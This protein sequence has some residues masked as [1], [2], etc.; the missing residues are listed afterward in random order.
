MILIC[1]LLC[2]PKLPVI[3]LELGAYSASFRTSSTL[4]RMATDVAYQASAVAAVGSEQSWPKTVVWS[5]TPDVAKSEGSHS[6]FPPLL[7]CLLGTY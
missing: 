2:L 3:V 5:E 1:G 7:P 6:P 4:L